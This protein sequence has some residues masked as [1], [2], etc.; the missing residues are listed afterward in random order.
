MK[1]TNV[2]VLP[3]V[4]WSNENAT[5]TGVGPFLGK[6][7]IFANRS[8]DFFDKLSHLLLSTN[9]TI[10][11]IMANLSYPVTYCG[12]KSKECKLCIMLLLVYMPDSFWWELWYSCWS[13]WWTLLPGFQCPETVGS[14]PTAAHQWHPRPKHRPGW[15]LRWQRPHQGW[16]TCLEHDQTGPELFV[17]PTET[18]TSVTIQKNWIQ[19]SAEALSV[20][21][22]HQKQFFI[23]AAFFEIELRMCHT[24]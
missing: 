11:A 22:A 15:L 24:K 4:F 1:L 3:V 7:R 12:F 20:C 23:C 14:H 9:S 13:V 18:S 21:W 2:I 5:S 16:Q 6:H 17:E 10:L 8:S 19:W